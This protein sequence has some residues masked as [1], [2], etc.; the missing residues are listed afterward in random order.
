[1]WK[2]A[3]SLSDY[4]VSAAQNL[5][6]KLKEKIEGL[7]DMPFRFPKINPRQ[8]YRGMVVDDYVVAYVVDE[9]RNLVIIIRVVHGM[10]NYQDSI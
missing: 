7:S 2:I 9:R 1:M 10:R 6:I 5:L 4:S 8:E 3:A